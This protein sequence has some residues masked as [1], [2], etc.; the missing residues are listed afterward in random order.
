ML[1]NVIFDMGGVLI[2][3]NR[4]ACIEAFRALGF[5]QIDDYIGEFVQSDIFLGLEEGRLTEAQFYAAVR[6]R[7]GRKVSDDDIRAAWNEFLLTI[8][9][10]KLELIL[11]LKKK[12][13]V[14]LLSN[15]NPI[16]FPHIVATQFG[17]NGHAMADYFDE[18]FLSYELH[19][20][21]PSEAIFRYL[22]DEKGILP[23]HSLLIDDG[24]AN[25]ETAKKLGFK[26]YL[27]QPFE[28]FDDLKQQLL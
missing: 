14:Y 15:T 19:L 1:E 28:D 4:K 24:K 18:C 22:M 8:P 23:S 27:A 7:I 9:D 5:T 2:D 17:R 16:H 21:K 13:R 26:T 11:A 6:E 25:I 10:K 3:L 20:S 12:Y